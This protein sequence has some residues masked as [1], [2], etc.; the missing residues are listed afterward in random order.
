MA[1]TTS[2]VVI[3]NVEDNISEQI[4]L[5][6]DQFAPENFDGKKVLIKPNILGPS[7]PDLAHTTD[8]RI[9]N[10]VV[11]E[12]QSRNAEVFVG[13]NPGGMVKNS[14]EVAKITGIYDASEGCYIPFSTQVVKKTGNHTNINFYISKLI[15]EVDYIINLPKMKSHVSALNSGAIKNTFGYIPGIEKSRMHIKVDNN[16]QFGNLICDIFETRPPDLNI[17][18]AINILEYNGPSFG[19]EV[20]YLGKLLASNDALALDSVMTRMMGLEVNEPCIIYAACKR[21][22]GNFEKNT[23]YIDGDFEVIQNYKL[24][25]TY[26]RLEK[27]K[28][29]ICSSLYPMFTNRFNIKPLYEKSKCVMCGECITNCPAKSLSLE[30]EF[31]IDN[32]CISCFCCVELCHYGALYVPDCETTRNY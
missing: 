28:N 12:C 2:K 15:F 14:T 19:G 16:E 10:A 23:I 30:P 8:P 4:K 18:D 26:K 3:R 32:N 6:M 17:M 13:D 11:K 24:P 31:K 25:S 27:D 20:R 22:L 5:I 7:K 21:E 29:K 9:V 1:T